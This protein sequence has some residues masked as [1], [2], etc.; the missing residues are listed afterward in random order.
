ML[1]VQLLAGHFNLA[2]LTQITLVPYVLL[3]LAFANRD[4]PDAT[5]LG[6]KW[7][8]AIAAIAVV[9]AFGLAA[10]QLGPRGN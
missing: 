5:R 2:F 7:V 8:G 6:S 9:S 3:R 1:T 4:L 10:L